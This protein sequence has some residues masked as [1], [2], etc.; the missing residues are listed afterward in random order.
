MGAARLDAFLRRLTGERRVL[1]LG[2]LAV[3]AHGL[4]RATKDADIWLEPMASADEWAGVLTAAWA[5]FSDLR[6]T[7]LPHWTPLATSAEIAVAAEETGLV[8]V[9]GL[10]CPLD[11]FREP[12]EI[13]IGDFEAMW[14][15]STSK[16]D[17]V[18]VL[19][20]VDL[21]VSKEDTGR[22][23]DF[24]DK[25]FLESKIRTDFGA[26]LATCPPDEAR[27]LLARYADHVVCERAL[28]NPDA[29]VQALARGV[30]AEL[31]AQG[32][33]FSRDALARLDPPAPQP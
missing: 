5:D 24:A 30:L 12:N 20:P 7:R 33:W 6:L 4:S 28:A 27:A 15:R 19:D 2:G 18:R 8:R 32:D 9:L 1:L 23:V 11:V 17:G 31:A 13:E 26:R 16:E 21:L 14:E 25:R 10:E 3:I 22:D 29:A